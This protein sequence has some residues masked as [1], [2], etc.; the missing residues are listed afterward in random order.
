MNFPFAGHRISFEGLQAI[1]SDIGAG[2]PAVA[3]F[4]PKNPPV[5][6]FGFASFPTELVVQPN[7]LAWYRP[8]TKTMNLTRLPNHTAEKGFLVHE[9]VHAL[10]HKQG[11]RGEEPFERR[12]SLYR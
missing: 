1:A 12:R 6:K 9:S 8:S 5:D 7:A 3:Y 10:I 11:G 4:D 2:S